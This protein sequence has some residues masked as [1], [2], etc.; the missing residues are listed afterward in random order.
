[1]TIKNAEQIYY[2]KTQY[3]FKNDNKEYETNKLHLKYTKNVSMTIKNTQH[4]YYI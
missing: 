3:K 1:M 4:I 2:T